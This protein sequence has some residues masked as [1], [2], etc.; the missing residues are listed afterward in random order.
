MIRSLNKA[1][2]G[3]VALIGLSGTANAAFVSWESNYTGA[4][5]LIG[6]SGVKN[7]S[8]THD[9]KPD[10]FDVYQ[11]LVYGVQLTID[12]KDDSRSD[13]T[14]KAFIDLPGFLADSEV[15]T[16]SFTKD[17]EYDS[18]WSL[19]GLFELNL[20][21]TLTFTITAIKGDFLFAGSHLVA[22]GIGDKTTR[23]SVPEPSTLALL[24]LG[25]LGV[26]GA[27][28]RRRA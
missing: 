23:T 10:G 21:G 14:E 27:A 18:G 11:D 16:F 22:S 5:V 6:G 28:R 15:G 4:D 12:L 3:I 24:G 19:A 13:T 7:F 2:I 26:A 20:S 1:L 8:Y 17:D 25:L 9:I